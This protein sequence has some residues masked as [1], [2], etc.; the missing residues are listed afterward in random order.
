V[1]FEIDSGWVSPSYG[2]RVAAPVVTARRTAQSDND[3]TRFTL[4]I[5]TTK[6]RV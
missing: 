5:R 3:V 4:I 2:V 1:A 6:D